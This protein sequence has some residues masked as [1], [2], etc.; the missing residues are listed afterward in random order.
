M[1]I[2]SSQMCVDAVKAVHDRRLWL[3]VGSDV[4]SSIQLGVTCA[5]QGPKRLP[6]DNFARQFSP[7]DGPHASTPTTPTLACSCG[8]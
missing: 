3:P 7:L 8:G 6:L 4:Y 1:L 5:L 2:C